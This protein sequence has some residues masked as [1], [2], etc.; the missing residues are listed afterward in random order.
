M[1][2]SP[3]AAKVPTL[4]VVIALLTV[5]VVW[6]ST[7]LAIRFALQGYP[8]LFFPA[9][10]FLC[11]GAIL[12][13]FLQLRGYPLPTLRQW[14]DAALIGVLLLGIG[15]GGVV[16]AERNVGSALAA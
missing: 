5:Y 12:F 1:N 6:G 13:V 14:R 16:L 4:A 3:T 10:R 7:Y 15:N 11:A 2:F 9:L 8:P